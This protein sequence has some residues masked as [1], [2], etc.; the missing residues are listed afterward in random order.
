MFAHC[1]AAPESEYHA[2]PGI[3]QTLLIIA[4]RTLQAAEAKHAAGVESLKEGWVVELKKQK[5]AWTA[6]EKARRE[7]WLADKTKQVKEL[8]VK[9]DLPGIKGLE[10]SEAS[11]SQSILIHLSPER[12][13]VS[14]CTLQAS[15]ALLTR[16]F[17]KL[18]Q[19]WTSLPT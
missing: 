3:K 7:T 19:Q 14:L 2:N 1:L 13:A 18:T 5:E 12:L 10:G 16:C 17:L 8:T 9:V 4:V 11:H 6:A 15:E